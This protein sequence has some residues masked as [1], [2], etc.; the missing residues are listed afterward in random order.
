M[1]IRFHSDS[2]REEAKDNGPARLCDGLEEGDGCRAAAEGREECRRGEHLLAELRRV[3]EA[4][5]NIVLGEPLGGGVAGVAED[6]EAIVVPEVSGHGR[7]RVRGGVRGLESVDGHGDALVRRGAGLGV[8]RDGKDA[9][10]IEG[11]GHGHARGRGIR[12]ACEDERQRLAVNED[13][14]LLR[15]CVD[16]LGDQILLEINVHRTSVAAHRTVA[17]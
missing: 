3:G 9:R 8:L 7:G 5:V 16:G 15:G 11:E 14:L 17:S 4:A 6:E 13:G 2:E 1:L 12:V 10:S